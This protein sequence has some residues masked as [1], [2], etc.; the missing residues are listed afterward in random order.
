LKVL[1]KHC[2]VISK[3]KG[4]LGLVKGYFHTINTGDS[5]PIK[6]PPHRLNHAEKEEIAKQM[7]PMI[8]WEVIRR[9]KSPYAAPVVLAKKKDNTWCFCVDLRA[10]N[11]ATVPNRYPIPRIDA[12]F[13]QL[14]QAQYFSTMDAN[15]GYWQIPMAPEDI[16]KT[17]F[18]THQGLFKFTR[19]PFALTGALGSYQNMTDEVLHDEIHGEIPVVTQYLDDTCAYT[20][21]W[22]DHLRALD[23]ILTKLH[24]INLKLAPKKC[25]FG[26]KSA[27][28]LGHIIRKNQLQADPKKVA[29]VNNWP[30]PRNVTDIRPF[31]G[32]AG[33][34]R[35]LSRTSQPRQKR[36]TI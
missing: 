9:S 30:Q 10:L 33:Y 35:H 3:D 32:L 25:V 21:L 23:C 20:V 5:Q 28:H 22:K 2:L 14:G 11:K 16:S 27:E 18:I 15:A 4:D 31:L 36:S 19:R 13:D 29:A 12:I 8:E 1:E 26:T 24:K 6:L 17:A 7:Q 34:Y